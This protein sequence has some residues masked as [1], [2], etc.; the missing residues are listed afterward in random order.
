MLRE[1]H[2]LFILVELLV[3]HTDFR[4]NQRQDLLKVAN[5]SC[6]LD[7]RYVSYRIKKLKNDFVYLADISHDPFL[8]I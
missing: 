7:Q 4:G 5:G 1:K 6:Y 2:D 3:V 8:W